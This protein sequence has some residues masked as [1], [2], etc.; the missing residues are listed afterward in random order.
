MCVLQS[1]RPGPYPDWM[2]FRPATYEPIR[3]RRT[4]LRTMTL[5]DVDAVHEYQSDPE[6]CRYMLYEPR[7]RE[8]VAAKVAQWQHHGRLE[9]DGDDLELAIDAVGAGVIG[10]LYFKLVSVDDLT[11]E[12][13]WAL[14]PRYQGHGYAAEGASALLDYAFGGLGLH[15]VKAELDPRN[16]DSAALCRRLG[17][18]EEA[19]FVEDM[20][21]KGAWG[22]TAVYAILDREWRAR[23][24]RQQP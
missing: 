4:L 21:F 18:R 17:M 11:A 20:W 15:R 7:T 5:D 13:G 12:I 19:H 16:A 23:S 2:G 3:T 24:T 1:A 14:N 10:H 9:R 22:D 6:V 8:E